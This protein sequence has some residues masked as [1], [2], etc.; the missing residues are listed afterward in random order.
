M[1][2]AETTL[3]VL[4]KAWLD[5]PQVQTLRPESNI[6]YKYKDVCYTEC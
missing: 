4:S 2:I 5:N 1:A 6:L 3:Y